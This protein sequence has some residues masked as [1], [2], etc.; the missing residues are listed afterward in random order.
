MRLQLHSIDQMPREVPIWRLLM[1]DL[2]QPPPER[3]AR[4]LGLSLRSI[5]R[6]NSTG[7]APRSVCLAVFWLT[8][9][10]RAQ[11]HS[12]AH[13]DALLAVSLAR[14]LSDELAGL[15][16]QVEHLTQLGQFGS[17][18]DPLTGNLPA[19]RRRPLP[20]SACVDVRKLSPC[21]D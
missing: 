14:S 20:M 17:A 10:G 18:N 16:R 4:V 11:V 6:Y 12:Q 8:S 3:V 2:C 1:D 21:Q 7:Q 9:W 15:R 13:N 5:Q 19:P